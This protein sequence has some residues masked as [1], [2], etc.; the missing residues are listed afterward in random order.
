MTAAKHKTIAAINTAQEAANEVA[1]LQCTTVTAGHRIADLEQEVQTLYH[2]NSVLVQ[3][4]CQLNQELRT[5]RTTMQVPLPA[6]ALA[7][8]PVAQPATIRT[9]SKVAEPV[10]YKGKGSDLILK[11]WLQKLGVWFY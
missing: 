5:L 2:N 8:A 1:Q 10:K 7:A 3:G 9:C 4:L 11:Q 6:P